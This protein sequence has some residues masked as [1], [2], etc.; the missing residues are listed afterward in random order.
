MLSVWGLRVSGCDLQTGLGVRFAVDHS[1]G[2]AWLTW[3]VVGSRRPEAGL[4]LKYTGGSQ[5]DGDTQRSTE[6]RFECNPE[7][8]L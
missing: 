7:V 4:K 1:S 6:Y 2:F 5:C 3:V 8:Q